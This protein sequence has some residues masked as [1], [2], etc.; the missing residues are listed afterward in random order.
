MLFLPYL[1]YTLIYSVF[2]S[3]K[4][5]LQN[6]HWRVCKDKNIILR[7]GVRKHW[8]KDELGESSGHRAMGLL[9]TNSNKL[10]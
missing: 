1:I 5:K 8:G 9:I 4:H 7:I 10:L 6:S 3:G 2:S